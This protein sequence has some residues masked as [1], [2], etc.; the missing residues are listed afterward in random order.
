M[1]A[2]PLR[3]LFLPYTRLR[4]G[5]LQETGKLGRQRKGFRGKWDG[6]DFRV[7]PTAR[8]KSEEPMLA[9]LGRAA[10]QALQ[11]SVGEHA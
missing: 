10:M 4:L 7:C 2:G 8:Y 3:L 9:S 11:D 5:R 1:P 6:G